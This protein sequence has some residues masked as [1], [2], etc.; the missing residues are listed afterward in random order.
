VLLPNISP[1]AKFALLQHEKLDSAYQTLQENLSPPDQ[2]DDTQA[3][4]NE[5]SPTEIDHAPQS[6]GTDFSQNGALH[7]LIIL[8][9][10][11][12]ASIVFLAFFFLRKLLR[13]RKWKKQTIACCQEEQIVRL[14]QYL[15]CLLAS[16][17]LQKHESETPYEF[18]QRL[19]AKAVPLNLEDMQVLTDT[20]VQ[21]AYS[22]HTL[23]SENCKN[24]YHFFQKLPALLKRKLG[25]FNYYKICLRIW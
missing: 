13:W 4:L 7:P 21:A 5:D 18:C 12:I 2:I 16:I 25:I 8:W 15:L 22:Q 10:V 6:S 20:F 3:S 17:G 23:Q 19:D 11:L 14:Y 24:Y 9:I 1:D